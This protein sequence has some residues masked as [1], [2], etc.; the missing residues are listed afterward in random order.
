VRW[1]GLAEKDPNY[2]RE[3]TGLVGELS[4]PLFQPLRYY[5]H[6]CRAGPGR[7]VALGT[8]FDFLS[9]QSA[10]PLPAVSSKPR[11]SGQCLL[12]RTA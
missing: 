1:L 5:H 6:F 2:A 8:F 7:A 11:A 12:A 9:S 4:I 3:R 10:G